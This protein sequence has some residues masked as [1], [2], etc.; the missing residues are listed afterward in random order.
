MR[1]NN[2]NGLPYGAGSIQM[3]GRVY[4]LIYT[5]INGNKIQENTRTQDLRV[6][7]IRAAER[8]L[9][10]TAAFMDQMECV[11]CE[12]TDSL[13]RSGYERTADGGFVRSAAAGNA[14][15]SRGMDRRIK[16]AARPRKETA[17]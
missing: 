16:P 1:R 5:D 15:G 2:D 7:R 14:G 10:R 6:A 3:R 9:E 11:I 8:A 17:A 4:W 12:S 13:T